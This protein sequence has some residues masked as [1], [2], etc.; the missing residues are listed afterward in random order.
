[1]MSSSQA[2][3][4]LS[5]TDVNAVH[6]LLRSIEMVFVED[7]SFTYSMLSETDGW[8]YETSPFTTEEQNWQ[9]MSQLTR[10]YEI[11]EKLLSMI[12]TKQ[13]E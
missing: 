7:W 8:S 11:V 6:Q 10:N 13:S 9:N 2:N 4:S 1:M 5:Q 12:P 3:I